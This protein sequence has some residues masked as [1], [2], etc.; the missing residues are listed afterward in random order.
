[1]DVEL[2]ASAPAQARRNGP[3]AT[4]DL[5]SA[6]AAPARSTARA[7]HV[8][9][10][11]ETGRVARWKMFMAFSSRYGPDGSHTA[12]PASPRQRLDRDPDDRAPARTRARGRAAP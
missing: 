2:W 9:R 10:H 5:V 11:A 8:H 4:E 1:M 12:T 7:I 6:R 3:G